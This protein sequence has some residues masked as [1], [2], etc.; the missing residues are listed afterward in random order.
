MPHGPVEEIVMATLPAPVPRLV[1]GTVLHIVDEHDYRYGTGPLVLVV[2]RLHIALDRIPRGIEWLHVTGRRID[3]QGRISEKNS[4]I[5]IRVGALADA[6]RHAEWLPP[7]AAPGQLAD[8]PGGGLRDT[9]PGG[10][11]AGADSDG[12]G[13]SR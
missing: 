7:A 2:A 8:P 10:P 12:G 4:T 3:H 1:P 9:A 5:A 11:Q 13:R 6:V